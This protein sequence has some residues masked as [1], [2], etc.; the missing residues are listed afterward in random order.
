MASS[1][2]IELLMVPL[3]VCAPQIEFYAR[4]GADAREI[5]TSEKAFRHHRE[6]RW[7]CDARRARYRV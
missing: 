6:N 7:T 1:R 2:R 4:R 3:L 5:D